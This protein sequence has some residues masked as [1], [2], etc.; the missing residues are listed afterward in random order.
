MNKFVLVFVMLFVMCNSYAEIYTWQDSQGVVHFS[1]MPHE[2]AKTVTIPEAQTFAPSRSQQTQPRGPGSE[3]QEKQDNH[4]KTYEILEIKQPGNN[5]TIRN[6]D[7]S[8][9]VLVHVEPKLANGDQ[10]QLLFDNAPLGNPQAAELFELR[11]IFRGA[12]TVGVQIIN[13]QGDVMAS[14]DPVTFFMQRPR[15]NM[16]PGGGGGGG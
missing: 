7:G 12:H 8:L 2:G 9:Q 3:M 5:E 16:A 4:A 6:N 1:D 14:S 13:S 11:G 15:T 10:I